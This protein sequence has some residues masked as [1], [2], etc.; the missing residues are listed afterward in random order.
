MNQIQKLLFGIMILALLTSC[1]RKVTGSIQASSRMNTDGNANPFIGKHKAKAMILGVFH[2][3][4]PGLDSYK[5][6]FPFDILEEKRQ[7]ELETLLAKVA[8]YRPT[9]ILVESSRIEGDS[10]LEDRY[11]N[12]LKGSFGI[13]DKRNEI[14]QIAFKL[15]KKLGHEKVYASDASAGWFGV[16]LDWETFDEE[17]YLKNLGQF[18]K[19]SRDY[20][21]FYTESDSLK[22]VQSLTEHLLFINA[23]ANRLKDH[24]AYLTQTILSGAGDNYLGADSVGKWYRRNLRI[25]ANVL[26]LTD[27]DHEERILLIYGAGHVWQLRQLFTDSPDFDYVEVNGYLEP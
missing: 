5:E 21:K 27:F 1:N 20:E 2:F 3:D 25:Y 16:K 13:D 18:E 4:N 8:H 17:A 22:S 12:F 15:A 6:K 9:K 11:G 24:Q 23:P 14:Y 10:L 7:K 19:A 26:D